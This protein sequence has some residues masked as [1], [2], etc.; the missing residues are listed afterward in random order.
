M[1]RIVC[2]NNIIYSSDRR[3]AEVEA[4]CRQHSSIAKVEYNWAGKGFT[5]SSTHSLDS[6][7]KDALTVVVKAT[8]KDGNEFT[9]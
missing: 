2:Y 4:R 8:D 9:V 5:G 6:S 7:F 1:G 3:S